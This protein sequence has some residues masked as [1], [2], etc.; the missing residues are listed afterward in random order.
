MSI[1]MLQQNWK[2][3]CHQFV[4]PL[5]YFHTTWNA[6]WKTCFQKFS[7]LLWDLDDE[8]SICSEQGIFFI[9]FLVTYNLLLHVDT[10]QT[11]SF[12]NGVTYNSSLES[13]YTRVAKEA[14]KCGE[15][16]PI[17]LWASQNLY[18]SIFS[19][20]KK[21]NTEIW[22]CRVISIFLYLLISK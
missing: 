9:Q 19:G 4:A 20:Q 7:H 16:H 15:D 3:Y 12:W 5:P 21:Q 18:G 6:V 14:K 17:S 1:V 10:I 2:R 11:K 8:Q 22:G 13:E